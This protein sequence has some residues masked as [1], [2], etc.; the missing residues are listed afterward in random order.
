[1]VLGLPVQIMSIK[2]FE[3][4]EAWKES[5]KLSGLM[6][7][8]TEKRLFSKDFGLKDQ[9]QRAAVSC[10][11]NIAEG[12]DS[13]TNQQ[14]IQFLLYSRRSSSEVQS[15]LYIA[16]DRGYITEPEFQDAYNQAKTVGKLI[17]GF[18]TYLKNAKR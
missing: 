11:S 8:L 3:E 6:Y 17:N 18:I 9:I 12:F 1:M 13:G 14:F 5:R 15:I 16:L 2:N 10:A 7:R 4:I